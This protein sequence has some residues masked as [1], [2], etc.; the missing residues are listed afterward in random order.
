MSM[1]KT[2][3]DAAGFF[4][5]GG[6][7]A[8]ERDWFV[9][10]QQGYQGVFQELDVTSVAQQTLPAATLTTNADA[11]ALAQSFGVTLDPTRT[12]IRIPV[13]LSAPG[14][15][16]PDTAG[17][18]TMSTQPPLDAPVQYASGEA[19]VFNAIPTDSYQVI[20]TRGASPCVPAS[21]PAAV[22]ADGSV[23]VRTLSGFWTVGPA[24][25][26]A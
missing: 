1:Q 23:Q 4:V 26:C 15:S 18:F 20:V 17:D 24:M 21:H 12:V 6:V 9:L 25:V 13:A 2:Q 22:A 7:Q 19:I 3:T 8:N 16:T 14:G 11:A 10:E 5:L